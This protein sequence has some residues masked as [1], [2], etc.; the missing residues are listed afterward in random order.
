MFSQN[1]MDLLLNFGGMAHE[2]FLSDNIGRVGT[3]LG[4]EILK[5]TGEIFQDD[6][7]YVY[8]IVIDYELA[9]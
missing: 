9:A 8:A 1:I 4:L 5:M 7:G 6:A 3:L 2:D